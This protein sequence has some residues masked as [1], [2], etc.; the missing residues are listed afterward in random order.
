MSA[1][2]DNSVVRLKVT[3]RS[4]QPTKLVLEPAGEIYPMEPGQS[5]LVRYTGDPMPKL[6]IDIHN[7]ETKIWDEGVGTLELDE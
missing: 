7:D 4:S 3:N 6:A 5:R 2:P 1:V